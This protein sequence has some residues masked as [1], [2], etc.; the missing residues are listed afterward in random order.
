MANFNE[1]VVQSTALALAVALPAD[2]VWAV[3]APVPPPFPEPWEPA[4]LVAVA[5]AVAVS[6]A[7]AAGG[8]AGVSVDSS[9]D[10]LA[11]SDAVS[12]SPQAVRAKART[13]ELARTM[14]SRRVC[15]VVTFLRR[16]RFTCEDDSWRRLLPDRRGRDGLEHVRWRDNGSGV[17][18]GRMRGRTGG[19]RPLYRPGQ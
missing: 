2:E 7:E 16:S 17:G 6:D 1:P 4:P 18:A 13:A 15:K 8:V 12:P 10:T 5:V 9:A 14:A 11:D 3:P 19:G